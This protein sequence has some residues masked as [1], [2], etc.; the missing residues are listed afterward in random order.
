MRYKIEASVPV[1]D[2]EEIEV[3][4]E[5]EYDA[6]VLFK[7]LLDARARPIRLVDTKTNTLLKSAENGIRTSC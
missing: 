5:H 4:F 1:N 7:F 6:N 3:W 2:S